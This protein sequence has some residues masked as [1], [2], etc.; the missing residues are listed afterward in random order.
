MIQQPLFAPD[1]TAESD[2]F[3]VAADH[4]MAGN[5]QGH[6]VFIV[7]IAHG[8]IRPGAVNGAGY[9]AIRGGLAK[10]NF[11]QLPPDSFLKIS[12]FQHQR[13]IEFLASAFK[14]VFQLA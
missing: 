2:Q 3:T 7:G 8:T 5:N 9:I 1:T 12:S 14:V 4:A 11:F 10:G 6:R 13:H